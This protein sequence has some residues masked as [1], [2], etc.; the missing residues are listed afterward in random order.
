MINAIRIT[1]PRPK[2]SAKEDIGSTA[3]ASPPVVRATVSAAAAGA[4]ANAAPISGSSAW[5]QYISP[6]LA[7][8][9]PSMAISSRR[10]SGLPA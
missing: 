7:R 4:T 5:V 2:L 6:K 10:S 1:R 3:Q 9:A 8:P